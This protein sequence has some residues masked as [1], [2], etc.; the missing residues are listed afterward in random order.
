M[1]YYSVPDAIS[2]AYEGHSDVLA[3]QFLPLIKTCT[4]KTQTNETVMQAMFLKKVAE[5]E[6][7]VLVLYL[8]VKIL[9]VLKVVE[10]EIFVSCGG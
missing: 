4:Q 3:A 2:A 9:T 6:P 1:L 7:E 10:R 5:K 8:V